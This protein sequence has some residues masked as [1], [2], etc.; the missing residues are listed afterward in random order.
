M[1]VAGGL[2]LALGC[3]V[4][5][6]GCTHVGQTSADVLPTRVETP[7]FSFAR[8]DGDGWYRIDTL[9]PPTVIEFTRRSPAAER[10]IEVT[11]VETPQPV[12]NLDELTEWVENLPEGDP[13]IWP[14]PGHG[15][16]CVRNHGSTSVTVHVVLEGTDYPDRMIAVEDSLECVDPASSARILRFVF[17]QRSRSGGNLEGERE[18][19]A[20][21]GSV[22][23]NVAKN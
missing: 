18:A 6:G 15:A 4:L 2:G 17:S 10:K 21:L 16:V 9:N 19:D 8:P 23:F 13:R 5:V 20:F 22:Q 12:A 14:A 1:K 7:E 3:A 11:S